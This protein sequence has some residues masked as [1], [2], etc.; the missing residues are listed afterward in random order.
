MFSMHTI[1]RGVTMGSIKLSKA[2]LAKIAGS[3]RGKATGNGKV[4]TPATPLP[5]HEPGTV[6]GVA[7][8]YL[9]TFDSADEKQFADYLDQQKLGRHIIEWSYKPVR[10]RI[11]DGIYYTPD[12]RVVFNDRTVTY[13]EIKGFMREAARVRIHAAAERHPHQ[14]IMVRKRP[15]KHG[16]GWEQLY[17]SHAKRG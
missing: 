1:L 10:L 11:G 2:D 7:E 8:P 6:D 5:T 15:K 17:D 13:Y 9:E 16:G 3:K 12:F 4:K 14:F